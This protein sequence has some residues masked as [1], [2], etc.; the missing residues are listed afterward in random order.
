[1]LRNHA[2]HLRGGLKKLVDL[3]LDVTVVNLPHPLL[4]PLWMFHPG[5]GVRYLLIQTVTHTTLL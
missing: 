3:C 2:K 5:T 1:M 4:K